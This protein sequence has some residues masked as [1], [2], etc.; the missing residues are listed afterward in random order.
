MIEV[1]TVDKSLIGDEY[2]KYPYL[3]Q[4]IKDSEVKKWR[5][6]GYTHSSFTGALY[7]SKNSMPEWV[8]TVSDL[9]GLKN[10]GYTFYKMDTLDIMPPHY[11]HFETY[12]RIFNVDRELAHRAIVF[13]EDWKPGHYFEYDGD[14]MGKWRK[15]EYVLYS[16]D[17]EHAA[18]NIGVESRYTLQITG[19]YER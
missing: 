15:G 10:C 6:Q 17:I 3:K 16:A 7:G 14:L 2:L 8:T 12:S 19:T 13:L 4:P 11:D 5:E 1:G 18:S 9:I